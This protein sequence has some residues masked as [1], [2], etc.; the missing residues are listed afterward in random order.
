MRTTRDWPAE[1]LAGYYRDIW[2]ADGVVGRLAEALRIGAAEVGEPQAMADVAVMIKQDYP[3]PAMQLALVMA[4]LRR[5]GLPVNAHSCTECGLVTQP[6]YQHET[7]EHDE[8][9]EA[10]GE[11]GQD[12]EEHA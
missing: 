9:A 8:A 6:E 4:A 1:N 5:I 3:Q 7:R 2:T 10:A 11:E 12:A